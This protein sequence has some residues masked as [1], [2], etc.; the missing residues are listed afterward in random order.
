MNPA[1]FEAALDDEAIVAAIR[2]EEAR[3]RGEI[4]VHV[5]EQ[6]VESSRREAELAFERLG[7]T[8]TA[9]R[10]GVLLYVAP[11]ARAI[12]LIGDRGIDALC[13]EA[14]WTAVVEQVCGEFRAGRFTEGIVAAVRAV[15][16]ELA[17]HFPRRPRDEDGDRN[18]LPDG[19]SRG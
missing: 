2:E 4:R 15:G 14:F 1:E 16:A 18:E 11:G 13:G 3:S 12:V 6:E 19:V 8:A 5:A 9:E 17:R 10:N 7:M